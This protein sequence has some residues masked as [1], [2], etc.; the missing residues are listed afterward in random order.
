M[1]RQCSSHRISPPQFPTLRQEKYSGYDVKIP[2]P[3][4]WLYL[5]FKLCEVL[6]RKTAKEIKDKHLPLTTPFL[7]MKLMPEKRSPQHQLLLDL[8]Q[9]G[10]KVFYAAPRFHNDRDFRLHYQKRHII[11]N[12]AFIMPS[13][14]GILPDPNEHYVSFDRFAGSGWLLSEPVEVERILT[15]DGLIERILEDLDDEAPIRDR[16]INTFRRMRAALS[17]LRSREQDRI[18][19]EDDL[20]FADYEDSGNTVFLSED[21]DLLF[22][23]LAFLARRDFDACLVPIYWHTLE[24]YS[25]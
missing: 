3:S 7:R 14:I 13:D 16:L 11:R 15:G 20:P 9:Q 24:G 23:R 2:L 1:A 21:D 10:E 17:R 19:E 22:R 12:S 8:E 18:S 5:Q 4:A 25:T 6:V